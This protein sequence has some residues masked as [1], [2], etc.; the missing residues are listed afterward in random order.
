M[1]KTI[2]IVFTALFLAVALIPF[3]GMFFYQTDET[4]EGRTLAEKPSFTEDGK[5]NLNIGT[6]YEDY[7]GDH[8]AFRSELVDLDA[9]LKLDL[10]ATSSEDK[11][12]VG[13]DGWL[14]YAETLNDFSGTVKLS[15]GD[16][17]RLARIIKMESDYCRTNG[18]GYV[19]TV[20]PNKNSIYPEKMAAYYLAASENTNLENINEAL[21]KLGVNVC[22]LQESLISA[23]ASGK[24]L[25]YTYDSH[26]NLEGATVGYKAL[27]ASVKKECGFDYADSDWL[28]A[29]FEPAEREGDLL[30]MV[31]PLQGNV[32]ENYATE[33]LKNKYKTQGMMKTVDDLRIITNA[34]LDDQTKLLMFRDSFG[35][36]IIEPLSDTF[37]KATYLRATPFAIADYLD[38][39]TVVIREIVERNIKNLLEYAPIMTAPAA[40]D[41]DV[42]GLE[43]LNATSVTAK[44]EEHGELIHYF[45]TYKTANLP[46]DYVVIVT[47]ADSSKYQAFPIVENALG[48]SDVLGYSFYLPKTVDATGITISFF[49]NSQK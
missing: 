19:F 20:A 44:T 49:G 43:A 37:K 41:A 8:F 31:T 32:I 11:V 28:N 29:T 22:D 18:K 36:A 39:D 7:F 35:R 16:I 5:I 46:D 12:I 40:T 1:K 25:Y 13:K 4:A 14:F 15:D 9:T 26:W 33:S 3:A 47:T 24:Q 23:K 10:F 34:E 30:K 17:N 45:G 6:D 2:Y 38:A 48:E 27:L 21:V 42:A